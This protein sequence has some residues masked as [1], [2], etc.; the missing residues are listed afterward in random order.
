[1]K[2]EDILQWTTGHGVMLTQPECIPLQKH[3]RTDLIRSPA[4]T[5]QRL[6]ASAHNTSQQGNC[7]LAQQPFSEDVAKQLALF[8]WIQTV[9]SNLCINSSLP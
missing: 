3:L 8:K 1:M 6:A 5:M 2:R 7:R 9:T 4:M